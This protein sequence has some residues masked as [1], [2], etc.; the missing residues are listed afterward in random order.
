MDYVVKRA[1]G[2][3]YRM[4]NQEIKM[5]YYT[6]DA[7]FICGKWSWYMKA[8]TNFQHNEKKLQRGNNC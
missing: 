1:S 5:P 4:G 2:K 3:G 7:S 6:D 8:N